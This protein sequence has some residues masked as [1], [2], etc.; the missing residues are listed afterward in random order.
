MWTLR[1][2]KDNGCLKSWWEVRSKKGHLYYNKRQVV[3]ES[4]IENIIRK[5]FEHL[6]A[7][8]GDQHLHKRLGW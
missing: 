3:P 4:Q 7:T 2:E 5:Y 1:R 6:E 8:R